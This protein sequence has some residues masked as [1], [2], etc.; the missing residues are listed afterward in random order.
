MY[1]YNLAHEPKK[2]KIYEN[3]GHSLNEVS[4]EVYSEVKQ[5]L[6]ENLT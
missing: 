1:A 3:A 5:W 6:K 4:D 2:L